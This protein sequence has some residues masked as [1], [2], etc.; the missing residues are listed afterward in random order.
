MY[1]FTYIMIYAYTFTQIYV[2][3]FTHIYV[4]VYNLNIFRYTHS[5]VVFIYYSRH[6]TSHAYLWIHVHTYTRIIV[7]QS[8]ICICSTI[9]SDLFVCQRAHVNDMPQIYYTR[10]ANWSK[11][12]RT[13]TRIASHLYNG[14][15]P[16]DKNARE[17]K[18]AP[19]AHALTWWLL[20]CILQNHKTSCGGELVRSWMAEGQ[21]CWA[22]IYKCWKHA[23]QKDVFETRTG[24][25][26]QKLLKRLLNHLVFFLSWGLNT[27]FNH[28]IK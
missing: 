11:H 7:T 5:H 28:W 27:Q 9:Y 22:Q 4:L 20:W 13:I 12:D 26:V 24:F 1:M 10:R 17:L 19:G 23:S 18:L 2:Y 16:G 3:T 6:I 14:R 8:H 21:P 25:A 15:P